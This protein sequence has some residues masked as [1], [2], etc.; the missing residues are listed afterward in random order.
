MEETGKSGITVR[1]AGK[2]GGEAVK[3]KYGSD[4]YKQIGKLG[5]DR[6]KA[7][8]GDDFYSEIGKKGGRPIGK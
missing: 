4:Y 3:A 6:T 7:K 2:R 1:E 8:Y 5:G